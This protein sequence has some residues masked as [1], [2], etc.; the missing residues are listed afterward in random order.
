MKNKKEISSGVYKLIEW[1]KLPESALESPIIDL[2]SSKE[3][4]NGALI[5]ECSYLDDITVLLITNQM[6]RHPNAR[7]VAL[8]LTLSSFRNIKIG[9]ISVKTQEQLDEID[10]KINKI[11]KLIEELEQ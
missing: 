7:R 6:D 9:S 10:D 4:E 5:G 8:T 2:I 1:G 11:K 3:T